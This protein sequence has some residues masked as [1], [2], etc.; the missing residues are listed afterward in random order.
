MV[1]AT[2]SEVKNGQLR[3]TDKLTKQVHHINFTVLIGFDDKS[4]S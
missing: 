2:A 1:S 3:F 4:M